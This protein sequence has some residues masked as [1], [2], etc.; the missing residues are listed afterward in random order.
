MRAVLLCNEQLRILR[1]L[2][3][4]QDF[5][6]LAQRD[7]ALRYQIN[8]LHG[9]NWRYV[10][11]NILKQN[12]Q[13]LPQSLADDLARCAAADYFNAR[14]RQQFADNFL[15]VLR[16]DWRPHHDAAGI[17]YANSQCCNC[18]VI[19]WMALI[20]AIAFIQQSMLHVISR[21]IRLPCFL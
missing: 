15:V 21:V 4:L 6:R 14:T 16:M 13:F 7:N 11:G 9:C 20:Q 1:F 3:L 12:L 8:A 2:V 5:Q 18:S 10:R 19:S 17:W